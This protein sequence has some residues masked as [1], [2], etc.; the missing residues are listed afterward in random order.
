M[1]SRR[2]E[3][4]THINKTLNNKVFNWLRVQQI[5]IKL[6][7]CKHPSQA[8]VKDGVNSLVLLLSHHPTPFS[9]L[10]PSLLRSFNILRDLKISVAVTVTRGKVSVSVH[11]TVALHACILSQVNCKLSSLAL[12]SGKR[13]PQ[14]ECVPPFT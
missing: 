8:Y 6:H 13:G 5:Q 2:C 3:I 1:H 10:S 12:D 11:G 4:N 9:L 7:V 14:E